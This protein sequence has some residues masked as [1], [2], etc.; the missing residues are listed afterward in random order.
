MHPLDTT[1]SAELV[2]VEKAALDEHLAAVRAILGPEDML[3]KIT[4]IGDRLYVNVIA[5]PGVQADPL[6][7]RPTERRPPWLRE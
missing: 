3:H 5:P 2:I 6:A 1:A 4:T 7:N